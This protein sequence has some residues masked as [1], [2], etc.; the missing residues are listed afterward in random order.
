VQVIP[1]D[2]WHLQLLGKPFCENGFADA[3]DAH[4]KHGGSARNR[5]LRVGAQAAGP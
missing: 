3:A 4:H 1:L 2:E 5:D